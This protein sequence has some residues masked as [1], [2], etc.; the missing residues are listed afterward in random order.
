[1]NNIQLLKE[2]E[3]PSCGQMIQVGISSLCKHQ[4][5]GQCTYAKASVF[6]TSEEGIKEAFRQVIYSV[7]NRPLRKE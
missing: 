7:E 3:C 2:M 5:S 6:D 4:K 1:M